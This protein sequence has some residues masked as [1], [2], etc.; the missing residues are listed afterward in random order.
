MDEG[1]TLPL[2]RKVAGRVNTVARSRVLDGE[3]L[4][5]A[6]LGVL[7]IWRGLRPGQ[8]CP[9]REE[10]EK[11]GITAIPS[12]IHKAV[13]RLRRRNVDIRAIERQPGYWCLGLGPKFR[14]LRRRPPQLELIPRRNH[15][16]ANP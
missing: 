5:Y 2:L 9:V 3:E 11:L 15:G 7:G 4:A 13:E 16:P 8:R 10:L 12:D 14:R 6:V 1:R